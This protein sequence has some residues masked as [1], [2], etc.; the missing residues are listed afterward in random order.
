MIKHG[1]K[2]VIILSKMSRNICS[3]FVM[4]KIES[5]D[6]Y[7]GNTFFWR[8]LLIDQNKSLNIISHNK[9]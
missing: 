9:N 5:D 3:D 6:P 1:R 4:S 7:K 8:G 2:T